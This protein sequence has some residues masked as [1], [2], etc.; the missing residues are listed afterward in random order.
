MFWFKKDKTDFDTLS[1]RILNLDLEVSKLQQQVKSID[2]MLDNYRTEVK[3]LN[4]KSKR[5]MRDI[6]EDEDGND[7]PASGAMTDRAIM[8]AFGGSLPIE[9]IEKYKNMN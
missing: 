5:A 2:T 4:K 9:L 3:L 8:E 1:K 7:E 6:L